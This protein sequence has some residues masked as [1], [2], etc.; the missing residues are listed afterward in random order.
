MVEG[1]RNLLRTVVEGL[2]PGDYLKHAPVRTYF[3]IISGAMFLLT[4]NPDKLEKVTKEV[5]TSFANDD[6]ITL[7][8]VAK[9]SYMLACLN[10]CLREYP[11]VPT[12][13]PRQVPK[14]GCF[15][16]GKFVPESVSH[17]ASLLPEP[18]INATR[19]P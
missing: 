11:P 7:T 16:L 4:T 1:S 13:L 6:E 3:R 9:L 19:R 17:E 5:R 2:L 14:G 10:E 12:G 8:S 15:I 18:R